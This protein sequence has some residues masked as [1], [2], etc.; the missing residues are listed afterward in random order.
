MEKSKSDAG[1]MIFCKYKHA[2]SHFAEN[3]DAFEGITMGT[4]ILKNIQM[5]ILLRRC[6]R[7]TQYFDAENKHQTKLDKVNK[8]GKNNRNKNYYDEKSIDN[9]VRNFKI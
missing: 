6:L 7:K 4:R 1:E 5:V 3:M 2:Y 8:C 9:S